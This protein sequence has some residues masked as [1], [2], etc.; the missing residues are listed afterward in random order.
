MA[1]P[2]TYPSVL[3]R[4]INHLDSTSLPKGTEIP[5]ERI[6]RLTPKDLMR[7]F[8]FM[9]FGTE[10]RADDAKP[11]A[12]STTVEFWKKAL[13]YYMTNRL[14]TWNEIS[15]VGNPT[16]S[17]E[18]NDLIK[19]IK[20]KEVRKQGVQSTARRALTHE[21]FKSTLEELKNHKKTT[22][23]KSTSPIW[24]YGIPA[25]M[26]LQFHVIARID[27]TMH[28]RM[29]NLRRSNIFSY[30][31][32]VRLNWSK[33]V[34]EERDSPWQILLPS[35]NPL[36]CV[37][38]N[39]A[40]WLE[41][42]LEL[43]PHGNLTPFL[44]GFSTDTRDP[45]G[46]TLSK[47]VA[48][49]VLGG[50]IFKERNKEVALGVGH[51]P[52]GT[53]SIRKLASTH[54]RRSG[55]TKDERDIRG[56]WKGKAR[57]ADVY[58]DVELPWPDIKVAS[59]L[60]PGGPCRYVLQNDV[61]DQFVLSNVVPN[62]RNKFDD[63][64]ALIFG[65]AL[66][67]SIFCIDDTTNNVPSSICTRVRN[68]YRNGGYDTTKDPVRRV[69][70]VCTGHE[71]EVYIDDIVTDTQ[72]QAQGESNEDTQD[73]TQGSS[74][75]NG[76][77]DRPLRD[78]IRALQ[79][80]LQSVKAS[81]QEIEKR[82]ESNHCN[83]IRHL[84][85]ISSNIKRFQ[86]APARPILRISPAQASESAVLSAHPRTLHELWDEYTIGIGGS[87]PAKEYTAV[88]RGRVKYKYYRRKI[89]WDLLSKI[90]ATGLASHVV[91]DRIYQHYGRQCSVTEIIKAVR[92][93]KNRN[94]VPPI[95]RM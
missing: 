79:S 34:R 41:I 4:M 73:T 86:A 25:S 78:Q 19:Y 92:K 18:L 69:P 15:N 91:I 84:Q 47:K 82:A 9:V 56:R 1:P 53:H 90:I 80:Q 22:E 14:M 95:L 21:E 54:S 20:K 23:G 28:I 30:L 46:A 6:S 94:Y 29:E 87:K 44:F 63:E 76:L 55:A 40:I 74:Q 75:G 51:G 48:S 71:G 93:D 58:D 59:M 42:F 77:T 37:Y 52:L 2:A 31:L 16:R 49:D 57:V 89:V 66:M 83:E 43:Y 3:L 45:E 70:I 10:T 72:L 33:N 12:R 13:S 17:A 65:T 39:L 32:Q 26:C 61:D 60:C 27:D 64:T 88:E 35:M 36:Y 24:N 68:A 11:I 62:I 85:T 67:Y 81:I 7:W 38:L 50:K 8:N 5:R